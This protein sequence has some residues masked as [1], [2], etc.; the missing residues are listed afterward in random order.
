MMTLTVDGRSSLNIT[1]KGMKTDTNTK[2]PLY[3]GGVPKGTRPRGL[4]TT[5]TVKWLQ[6][7][8][9]VSALFCTLHIIYDLS[10]S[11]VGCV[12][13]LNV[14]KKPRKRKNVDISQVPLVGDVTKNSCPVN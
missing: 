1:K 11:F 8:E 4:E 3:L 5:G 13:I 2:D 7:K 12:R 6:V 9:N 14:G 10:E